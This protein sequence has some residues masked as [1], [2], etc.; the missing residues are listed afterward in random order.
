MSVTTKEHQRSAKAASA[1]AD[2][3]LPELTFVHPIPGF[4]DLRRFVLVR[5]DDQGAARP[6]AEV[7]A[8][9][10]GADAVSAAGPDLLTALHESPLYELRSIEQ[11][12]VRFMVAVPAAFFSDYSIEIDDEEAKDLHLS[13]SSDALVLVMLTLGNDARSTT[14]NLLA[15][16]IING[17]NREAAQVILTGT[18]WPVRAPL[19]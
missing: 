17:K 6:K 14:A 16:I 13:D 4:C 9:E 3:D 18:D 7:Q 19:D 8:N 1:L 12:E 5:F 2:S 10:S 15:P 11:S